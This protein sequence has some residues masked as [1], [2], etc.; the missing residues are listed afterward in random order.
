MK[1]IAFL[2]IFVMIFTV[3]GYMPVAKAAGVD[4]Y[5]DLDPD[6]NYN[7]GT[8]TPAVP[9]V[10]PEIEL[11]LSDDVY[12]SF[13]TA[14]ALGIGDEIRFYF[15][16][17][18]V[19]AACVTPTT[20]ASGAVDGSFSAYGSASST[21]ELT[22]AIVAGTS[23]ELCFNITTDASSTNG[24]VTMVTDGGDYSGVLVYNGNDND[25]LVTAEVM[26]LLFFEIRTP[27]DA[28]TTNECELG[29]LLPGN[30]NECQYR[31]AI[32]TGA[33]NGFTAYIWDKSA[34]SGLVNANGDEINPVA[35][36]SLVTGGVES[37][38]IGVVAATS[39]FTAIGA[40]STD[41][42]GDFNDDDTPIPTAK[43]Q[44][45]SATGPF[46]WEQGVLTSSSLVTHRAAIDNSTPTGAYT[47]TVSYYVTGNF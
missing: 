40:T 9:D 23:V 28:S 26:G 39:S 12:F 38:G 30:V 15:P 18:W 24:L 5:A 46:D 47:Q 34:T 35:E 11:G 19:S 10:E 21:Y 36:D 16:A 45:I 27:D 20:K 8:I 44:M 22:A 4:M 37:Y 2:T 31:L 29:L 7:A 6:D 32:E 17:G 25:V 14:S 3:M 1:K 41:E 43:T 13:Q 42:L 33:S